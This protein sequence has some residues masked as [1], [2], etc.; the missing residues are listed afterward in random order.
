[1]YAWLL[2]HQRKPRRHVDLEESLQAER[3]NRGYR[4][5]RQKLFNKKEEELFDAC[6]S[7][8]GCRPWMQNLSDWVVEQGR[9]PQ[10]RSTDAEERKHAKRWQNA[11]RYLQ[12]GQLNAAETQLF[13][14]RVGNLSQGAQAPV[15]E[16]MQSLHSWIQNLTAWVRRMGSK[17]RRGAENP[18]ERMQATRWSRAQG[19]LKLG[20][21]TSAE[22]QLFLETQRSISEASQRGWLKSLHDW[23]RDAGRRP[24]D[25]VESERRQATRWIQAAAYVR[26]GKFNEE[27]KDL[28]LR[29]QEI[30]KAHK[31]NMDTKVRDW[32]QSLHAWVTSHNKPHWNA[33]DPE[34]KLQAQ[35]LKT[36]Q[37]RLKAGKLNLAEE[38]LF[39]SC[40]TF[41]QS[42]T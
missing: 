25:S 5:V 2:E 28:F 17:P 8:L 37:Q 27:E 16:W 38:R 11:Q 32:L 30:A 10:S 23:V 3:L 14:S 19:L 29:C 7:L 15:R 31:A 35:R 24:R 39:Q 40:V 12:T 42:S 1:L 4:Y 26:T 9:L 13:E 22:A 41:L 6:T 20:H 33:S 34:E 21:L 36:A 18:L